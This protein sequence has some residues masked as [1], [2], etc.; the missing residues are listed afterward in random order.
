MA[1]LVLPQ[2]SDEE[3]H[4]LLKRA[5]PE[6]IQQLRSKVGAEPGRQYAMVSTLA[7]D[8]GN[9]AIFC[10]LASGG[11][12]QVLA[13][14]TN[15]HSKEGFRRDSALRLSVRHVARTDRR[16]ALSL[17]IR[18][19]LLNA[20]WYETVIDAEALTKRVEQHPID[21]LKIV[22][23]HLSAL[24]TGERPEQLV[25]RQALVLGG[26]ALPRSL[27]TGL[28]TLGS[29]C[30]VK[31]EVYNH[32]GPTETTIG[33]LINTLW[34]GSHSLGNQPAGIA[35]EIPVETWRH[36]LPQLFAPGQGMRHAHRRF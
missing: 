25:P 21:V 3:I 26:E 9:T 2:T 13:A 12:L 33:V 14:D 7:A 16:K 24:L 1:C 8:L 29:R 11:C 34:G 36:P 17:R 28:Q 4:D 27:L 20:G 18:I 30:K 23:S 5:D 35:R 6:L 31:P 15:L 22:P 10:A 32:Y 19:A